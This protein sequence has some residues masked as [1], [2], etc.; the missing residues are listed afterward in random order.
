MLKR[1]A[2]KIARTLGRIPDL[3]DSDTALPYLNGIYEQLM[4]K[5]RREL[6]STYTWAMDQSAFLASSLGVKSISALE[7]GVAGGNGLLALERVA[8]R[9]EKYFPVTVDVYGFDSAQGLPKAL[10][11]RDLPNLWR[12]AGYPMDVQRLRRR[13]RRAELVVGLVEDTVAQFLESKPAPIGFVS[14]DLD[15]YSSTVQAFGVLEA[16]YQFLMPRV[17]CYFDDILGYTC[18][19]HNGERLAISEFN[20]AHAPRQISQ[21]YGLRLCLPKRDRE[22][23]WTEKMFMTHLVE[24]PLY[25]RWDGLLRR[26]RLDLAPA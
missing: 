20:S 25:D 12:E 17:H 23:N 14:F 22:A 24:H 10:D 21:I 5:G 4:R 6:R 3:D 19:H 15:F 8:E 18:A 16:D 2:N 1:V 9:I 11:H 26:A 7:F 13:L